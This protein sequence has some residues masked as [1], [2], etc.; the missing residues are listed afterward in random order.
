MV[1]CIVTSS[2]L[3]SA[4]ILCLGAVV[5]GCATALV[6]PTREV[7]TERTAPEPRLTARELYRLA[8]NYQAEPQQFH[9]LKE[10]ADI[11]NKNNEILVI[12]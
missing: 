1:L 12:R 11:C 10:I 4:F 2:K 9:L 8:A 3:K 5:S 7:A 6:S